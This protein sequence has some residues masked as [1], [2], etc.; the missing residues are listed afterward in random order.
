VANLLYVATNNSGS[1]HSCEVWRGHGHDVEFIDTIDEAVQQISAGGIDVVLLDPADS[2]GNMSQ[3]VHQLKHLVDSPPMILI[4]DSPSA[5]EMSA[6]IGAAAF[7]PKPCD[8][9]DVMREVTRLVGSTI[10][11]DEPTGPYRLQDLQPE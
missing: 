11:D 4:S 1:K 2:L 6:R 7:V 3:L 9:S 10:F 8:D 5:P